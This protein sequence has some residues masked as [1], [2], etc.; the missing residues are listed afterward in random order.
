MGAQV[1]ES[2][3]KARGA[4]S[5]AKQA[6]QQ[7]KQTAQQV[8][9]TQRPSFK[10]NPMRGTPFRQRIE[11]G[12]NFQ[13]TRSTTDGKPAM[14]QLAATAGFKWSPKLQTGIG[15]ATSFGLGQDWSHIHFSFEGF[16][17]RVFAEWKWI[18][19]IGVYADYER[20]YK[21]F[22]FTNNKENTEPALM[23]STH[24]TA[25]WN[26]SVL[27]GLTK[28]YKINNKWNGAIQ[29]LYDV[30]WREKGIRSPLVLRFATMSR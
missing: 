3:N 11:K 5:E 25:T 7:V 17:G 30:W 28:S 16:G 1:S 12:Y 2:Q 13:T 8:K 15:L 22:A 18:Y 9:N 26:E 23:P 6:K 10:V 21:Q 29:V 19:G 4:L 20:T 14:L 24:N 27:L